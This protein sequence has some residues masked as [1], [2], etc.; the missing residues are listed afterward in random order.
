MRVQAPSTVGTDWRLL[1]IGTYPSDRAIGD[2][3]AV[4]R[5][6]A[7]AY[8]A[9][10]ILY[11]APHCYGERPEALFAALEVLA[12]DL[13]PFARRY[14]SEKDREAGATLHRLADVKAHC[15]SGFA[16]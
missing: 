15:G 10:T 6:A 12:P 2:G 16:V 9:A 14:L 11:A 5:D 1:A 13:V 3:K 7:I 8:V 4:S